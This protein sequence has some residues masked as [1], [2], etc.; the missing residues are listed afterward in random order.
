M[1]GTTMTLLATP[2][3]T[4]TCL[5]GLALATGCAS[6]T[7]PQA[8]FADAQAAISAADAVGAQHEPRAALHLKM[9]RDELAKARALAEDG[10]DDEARLAL[11][12]ASVDAEVAMMVTR[13]AAARRDADKSAQEVQGLTNESRSN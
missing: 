3:A 8:K 9:A 5:A 11:S 12:R 7:V 6:Q 10:D 13:E 4:L 1:K 2:L